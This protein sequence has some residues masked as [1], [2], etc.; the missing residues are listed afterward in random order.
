MVTVPFR[1]D[2]G[3]AAVSETALVL[4]GLNGEYRW[5]NAYRPVRMVGRTIRLYYI[6]NE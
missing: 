2:K 3:W 1:K 4:D 5:L 6:P